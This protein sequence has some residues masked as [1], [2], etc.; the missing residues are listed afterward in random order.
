MTLIYNPLLKSNL[1]K[2]G[3]GG[4][5]D[6]LTP[7]GD[8]ATG[9]LPT[10]SGGIVYTY[11]STTAGTYTIVENTC[12][13]GEFVYVRQANVAGVS[14]IAGTNVTIIN[15]TCVFATTSIGEMIGIYRSEDDG[16][17]QVYNIVA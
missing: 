9:N 1:Q 13:I 11:N 4:G 10:A 2:D 17:N 16:P 15:N 7:G 8:L 6:S 5:G 3:G 12:G 14:F